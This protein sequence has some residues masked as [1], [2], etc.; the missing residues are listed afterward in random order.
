[1]IITIIDADKKEVL[2]QSKYT[3]DAVPREGEEIKI[4]DIFYIVSKIYW[5]YTDDVYYGPF[6]LEIF[7]NEVFKNE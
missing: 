2:A 4:Y 6:K 7:V 1:M 5:E 3:V